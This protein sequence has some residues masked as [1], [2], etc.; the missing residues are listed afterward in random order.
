ME[1]G[2]SGVGETGG[3]DGETLANL[4][5]RGVVVDA[6]QDEAAVGGCGGGLGSGLKL[7]LEFGPVHGALNLWTAENWLAAQ[8]ARTMKKTKLER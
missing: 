4:D 5:G 7:G 6:E 8:T 2:A 1:E 3:G